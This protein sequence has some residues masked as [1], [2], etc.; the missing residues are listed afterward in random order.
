MSTPR[1]TK[2]AKRTPVR[3]PAQRAAGLDAEITAQPRPLSAEFGH[4]DGSEPGLSVDADDLAARYLSEAIEQ[5]EAPQ[6]SALEVELSLVNGPASD[7]VLTSANFEHENTL[8]EQTVELTL[9]T[10]GAAD[11]L[12]A[13]AAI[14]GEDEEASPVTESSIRELSLLDREDQSDDDSDAAEAPTEDGDGRRE[15]T[16]EVFEARGSTSGAR[17][18]AALYDALRWLLLRCAAALRRAADR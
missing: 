10:R 9:Q 14:E 8:W 16:A 5:G 15:R 18:P 7:E 6:R 11:Q 17:L 1:E 3:V 12:R 13:P 4:D 2:K